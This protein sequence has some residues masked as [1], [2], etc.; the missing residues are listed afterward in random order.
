MAS[1]LEI[2]RSAI[3]AQ[4]EALNVTG[5]NIVNANTEGYRRRDATLSEVSGVQSE[6]TSVT[7][8]TGL[9][10]KLGDVRRA[11]DSFLTES[12]RT[13]SGR[14]ESS[15]AFVKKLEQLENTILP[16]DG[17]LGVTLTAFFGALGQVAAQP[18]DLAPRAAAIEMGHTVS[19][20]F[21]TT[22]TLLSD[23]AEGTYDEIGIKLDEVNQSIEALGALNGQLRSSNLGGNPPNALLDERDRLIDNLSKLVPLSVSIGA[24]FEAEVRLGGSAAGPVILS[25]EDGKRLSLLQTDLGG[26]SFRIGSGQIVSQLEMGELRGLVDAHGT[27]RRAV[28]EL[29]TLAR[30]FSSEM[31]AQ[32]AQ[33]IDLEGQLG[34]E[35]FGVASFTPALAA[36]NQGSA[37]ATIRLVPGRA[38]QLSGMKMNFEART[39]RWILKDDQGNL[40]GTGRSRIEIDGAVIDVSGNAQ[41]GDT[42]SF[43]RDSG[44]ALR[45]EFLLRRP[46][47]IA[48]ASTVTIYPETSNLGTAV[49][50]ATQAADSNTGVLP[51]TDVLANNLSPVAAQDFLRGGVVGSIPRGTQ[52]ITLASLS[53]QASAYVSARQDADIASIT[54]ELDGESH[55]FTLSPETVGAQVWQSGAEIAQYLNTGVLQSAE[56]KTLSDLGMSVSGSESGLALAS[57]GTRILTGMTALASD[58]TALGADV[59]Q[60]EAASDIRIFT[61]E[62]RQIAGTPLSASEVAQVLTVENGFSSDAEYRPDYNT[63]ASGNT[64][65]GM[66]VTQSHTG[67]DP[68]NSGMNTVS[69]SL[70]GL[71]GSDSS[72]I[73]LD[74]RANTTPG[75]TITLQMETGPVRSLSIPPGVDAAYLAERANSEFAAVGVTATAVTVV[76]LTLDAPDNGF[77]QFDITG[78]NGDPLTVS[79]QVNNGDLSSLVDAVNRRF[80]D[81][82]VRAEQ[83]LSSGQITLIQPD[84]YDIG[85]SSVSVQGVSFSVSALDQAFQPLPLDTNAQPAISVPLQDELR[86]SGTLQFLSGAAFELQSHVANV[87]DSHTMASAADPMSG[88]LVSRAFSNGGSS[89]SLSY[90]VDAVLDGGA[91]NID[92][93][94]VH[95]PS[96]RFQTELTL[97]DGT[98]LA[99]DVQGSTIPSVEQVALDT[100]LQL[101]SAA[102]MPGLRGATM[103]PADFPPVGTKASF[104]LG[105]ATYTLERVGDGDPLQLSA[106]DFKITGPE[107]G[108]VIPQLIEEDGGYA[109][110]LTVGGGQISGE[111][112]TPALNSA[113]SAFG[114]DTAQTKAS[115]QGRAILPDLADGTYTLEVGLGETQQS[116]DVTVSG[117]VHFVEVPLEAQS[118][119]AAEIVILASGEASLQLRALQSGSGQISV[120]PGVEAVQ[121]GFNTAAVDLTVEGGTLQARSTD[122]AAINIRA[123]GVSAASSYIHLTDIPDEELIVVM[124]DSGAKRLAAQFEMGP[125]LSNA[126]RSP[127][128][129]RVEMIDAAT[130]RVELFDTVSGASIATR[131]S[132]GLARFNISGQDIEL[133][134][135]AE[136]GDVFDLATGQRSAGDARNMDALAALGQYGTGVS[137]FQDDFRTIAA[138]VGATLEAARLTRLSNEAVQDAAVAAESELSGVNLDEEAAKLMSQ[139]QAYQAAARILQTAREMFDTLMQIA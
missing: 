103:A 129:F 80:A 44:D 132:N 2:G 126:D 4:R 119:L 9:G 1:L 101:R 108:R 100:V 111:G 49:L 120:T 29:D 78:G 124:G 94:R 67:T 89:A 25:G 54:L 72:V 63:V 82:G 112:L 31:N 105:G 41:D 40:L 21:N 14:F 87:S 96:L 32:H 93:T 33:G 84:G 15:D 90:A 92:G 34:K 36:A 61:R 123:G 71:R 58:G 106:L 30:N 102:P 134:G 114:L 18:G 117:G 24:R 139:Q 16:N 86:I 107:T 88:G 83:S 121:L 43:T 42:V 52:E 28:A 19:N 26:I 37:E 45:I 17:D 74:S 53:T 97:S 60:A 20:A 133:S 73:S 138:G 75:Q 85:L 7:S 135:F 47:E 27:T 62:G 48:A 8:Q 81:T 99:A 65:R 46:E 57:N 131:T 76:S 5:Q 110:S 137:S 35:L 128:R 79:A 22:A 6:L 68:L 56:G 136:T 115:V 116:I 91:A 12:K 95:A 11:F 118:H 50:N 10:V 127:E 98:T 77:V 69:T 39:D 13:A 70:A 104:V 3:H 23:L 38:D 122:G 113:A 64:Y 59:I 51:L 109:L 130:G 55:S 66:G 125:S